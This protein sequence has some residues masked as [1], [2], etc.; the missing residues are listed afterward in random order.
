M[1]E[2]RIVTARCKGRSSRVAARGARPFLVAIKVLPLLGEVQE[3]A[4][5]RPPC[6]RLTVRASGMRR[7]ARTEFRDQ[8]IHARRLVLY[9]VRTAEG[10]RRARALALV[11]S[12]LDRL[13]E[14]WAWERSGSRCRKGHALARDRCREGRAAARSLALKGRK[15]PRLAGCR[16]RLHTDSAALRWSWRAV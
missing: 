8:A 14:P 12:D 11:I 1:F 15:T 5:S 16:P 3:G 6:R 2:F 13:R 4:F 9:P 7:C 10:A